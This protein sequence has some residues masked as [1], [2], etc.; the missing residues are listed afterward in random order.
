VEVAARPA[1]AADLPVLCTLGRELRAE[2]GVLRGGRVL[3]ARHVPQEPLEGAYEALLADPAA[4]VL[5]GTIDGTPVG[6]AVV[7]ADG[8]LATIAELF[9][10]PEARAVGVGEAML[11]DVLAWARSRGCTGVDAAALP[12]ARETKNF[13]ET[14]GLTARLLVVHR[15]L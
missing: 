10:D 11:D 15:R 1:T 13:F 5:L 3:V 14:F 7:T 2:V 12:G 8:D 9:V 4:L 6:H